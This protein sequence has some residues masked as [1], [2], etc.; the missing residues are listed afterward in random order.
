MKEMIA[1][2]KEVL[3]R[4]LD[5]VSMQMVVYKDEDLKKERKIVLFDKEYQEEQIPETFEELKELCK[6]I[7]VD[8]KLTRDGKIYC[9]E[10]LIAQNRTPSQMWMIIMGL[11]GK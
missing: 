9:Y 11:L 8:L 7:K 3:C 10:H 4:L 2:E 6:D 1:I 5:W